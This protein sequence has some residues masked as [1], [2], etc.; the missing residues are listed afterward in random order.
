MTPDSAPSKR[1]LNRQLPEILRVVSVDQPIAFFC[2]CDAACYRVV[3]LSSSEYEW[4][5]GEA[6]RLL[7]PEHAND[8]E[9]VRSAA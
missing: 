9:V 7:A 4:R 3:W 8:R 1:D 5:A 2:E 6:S